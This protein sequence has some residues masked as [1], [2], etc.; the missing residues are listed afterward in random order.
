MDFAS[1]VGI[2]SGIS[3]IVSAI[4]LSSDINNFLNV[5]GIMIVLGGT[6]AATL[7]TFPFRDVL[8]T[9]KA[10]FFVFRQEKQNPNEA[11]AMMLKLSAVSRRKGFLAL[12]DVKTTSPFLKRACN[13]IAD[14]ASEEMIRTTLRNEIEAMKIRHFIVQDVFKRMAIYAPAFGMLGTLIGLIQMLSDLENPGNIGPAMAIALLTT[15]YGSLLANMLFLPIAGKLRSRT[16]VEVLN[17]E[18]V[19]EGAISIMNNNNPLAVYEQLSSFIPANK[20]QSLSSM[21]KNK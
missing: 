9:F 2:V 10:A 11:I 6:T 4:F 15:F 8:S 7:L 5:P 21:K 18:I 16:L 19:Y 3:L 17:L 1:F 20:R 12:S 13:L 14:S